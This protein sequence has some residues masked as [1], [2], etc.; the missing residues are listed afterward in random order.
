MENTIHNIAVIS[1]PRTA[2]RSLA[3]HYSK[4]LNKPTALGV[5]HTS[6]F[7]HGADYNVREVVFNQKHVLHG[8][9]HSL[10]LLDEDIL[11]FIRN[12][13]KIVSSVRDQKLVEFS[14]KKVTGQT[15]NIP[16]L[17]ERTINEQ[18][19]W[20]VYKTHQM[21]GDAVIDIVKVPKG[22]I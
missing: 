4:I 5:L 6:E 10:N 1:F 14:L 8:H 12:N 19:K 20:T 16:K 21:C 15:S 17:I 2:S 22:W 11:E 13:Y 18:R 9:W 3:K 7:L